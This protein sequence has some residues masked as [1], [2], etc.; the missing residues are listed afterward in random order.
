MSIFPISNCLGHESIIEDIVKRLEHLFKEHEV[1][2]DDEAM[3]KVVIFLTL[4]SNVSFK[5]NLK[6]NPYLGHVVEVCPLMP[7]F[8]LIDIIWSLRLDKQ[9]YE[10]LT[11]T[12]CWFSFQFFEPAT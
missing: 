8:L 4:N 12:P 1:F 3:Q 5:H 10:L 7:T 2:S 11:Y 9:F 6:D